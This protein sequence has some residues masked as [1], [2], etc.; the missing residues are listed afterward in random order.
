ME[1]SHLNINSNSGQ[2]TFVSDRKKT[3]SFCLIRIQ[4]HAIKYWPLVDK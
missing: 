2:L 4:S 1:D 3:N